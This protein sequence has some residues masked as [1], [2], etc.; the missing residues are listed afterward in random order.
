MWRVVRWSLCS[1]WHPDF[2]FICAITVIQCKMKNLLYIKYIAIVF[3]FSF[4]PTKNNRT[5]DSNFTG[6]VV[7]VIVW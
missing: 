7:V 3:V 5:R 1:H 6:A 2:V 4:N